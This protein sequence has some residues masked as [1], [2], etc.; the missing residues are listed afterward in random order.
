MDVHYM[1]PSEDDFHRAMA[2]YTDWLDG[3][4]NLQSVDHIVD[5]KAEKG[6]GLLT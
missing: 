4:L 5:Q 6:V 1:A 3:Q 2:R